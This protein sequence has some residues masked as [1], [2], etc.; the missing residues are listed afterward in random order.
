MSGLNWDYVWNGLW[1]VIAAMTTV[2]YGDFYPRTH[3]G[4]LVCIVGAVIGAFLVSLMVVAM[5]E[6]ST[7]DHA[8]QRVITNCCYDIGEIMDYD[9]RRLINIKKLKR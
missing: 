5:S 1:C 3:L 6:S 7:F 4:R 8:E 9:R 2:G